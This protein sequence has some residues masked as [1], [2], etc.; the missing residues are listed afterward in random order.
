MDEKRVGEV[1]H[2]KRQGERRPITS[3]KLSNPGIIGYGKLSY[4]L[5]CVWKKV[6]A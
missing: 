1:L 5:C 2:H 3:S 4:V 6:D